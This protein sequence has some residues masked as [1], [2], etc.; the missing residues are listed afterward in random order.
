MAEE[1]EE[2]EFTILSGSREEN[3]LNED[4]KNEIQ[5]NAKQFSVISLQINLLENDVQEVKIELNGRHTAEPPQ[6]TPPPQNPSARAEFVIKSEYTENPHASSTSVGFLNVDFN[7]TGNLQLTNT[8]DV[9]TTANIAENDIVLYESF[10]DIELSET[11]LGTGRKVVVAAAI[12]F[13]AGVKETD[14]EFPKT[15]SFTGPE[16]NEY[17]TNI[18]C[19]PG[20]APWNIG[21]VATWFKAAGAELPNGMTPTATGPTARYQ[22]STAQG[23]YNW[24]RSTYRLSKTPAIGAAVLIGK[25]TI[26]NKTPV[27]TPTNVIGIVQHINPKDGTIVV[28]GAT[29]YKLP[30]YVVDTQILAFAAAFIARHEGFVAYAMWDCDNWRIG[31][32]S[33]RICKKNPDGTPLII[34]L[35]SD[36]TQQ[37][38]GW[39]DTERTI[40]KYLE[41]G[42]TAITVSAAPDSNSNP[43]VYPRFPTTQKGLPWVTTDLVG[44]GKT[45]LQAK[46]KA[47]TVTKAMWK[48]PVVTE[49]M[50]LITQEDAFFDLQTRLVE[51]LDVLKQTSDTDKTKFTTFE[52]EYILKKH[53]YWLVAL[54]DVEYSFG[55]PRTRNPYRFIHKAKEAAKKD[56][57]DIFYDYLVFNEGP[58][59]GKT[60]VTY[61]RIQSALDEVTVAKGLWLTTPDP[62]PKIK[63]EY[64]PKAISTPIDPNG[65]INVS[66]YMNN[67]YN[68]TTLLG[69]EL[70]QR[71]V[72]TK[73]IIGYVIAA[74][75][76][77]KK[78][79]ITQR[80][81]EV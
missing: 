9:A 46:S 40:L 45:Q 54:L 37:P 16:I 47:T 64:W 71:I 39:Q 67:F 74:T 78:S 26:K 81:A 15:K 50:E 43:M 2:D 34:E 66:E 32:G 41:I 60:D 57:P 72:N 3:K 4:P 27:T 76:E 13:D 29:P 7:T 33:G 25:T 69:M 36:Y 51:F 80:R 31:A 21:A 75:E 24:A 20:S 79:M 59:K 49:K 58:G 77:D 11:I 38:I 56:N 52:L 42:E 48:P 53:P 18:A 61:G 17:L 23:W 1:E 44:I 12:D 22:R 68:K 62:F 5:E 63:K 30:K 14:I 35:N 6:S 73:D 28:L 8:T 70:T 19:T 65:E 10:E 55:P